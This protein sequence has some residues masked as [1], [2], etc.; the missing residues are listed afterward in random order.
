LKED[1]T[2]GGRLDVLD[3]E[4]VGTWGESDSRSGTSIVVGSEIPSRPFSL[5]LSKLQ[6]E[7]ISSSLPGMLL[8]VWERIDDVR[9]FHLENVM[10][11]VLSEIRI[12]T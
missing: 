12:P 11:T 3:D 8:S 5:V 2:V 4:S 7:C 10:Q 1:I 6:S 9:V